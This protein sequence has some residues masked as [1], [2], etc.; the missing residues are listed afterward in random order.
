LGAWPGLGAEMTTVNLPDGRRITFPDG[1][2]EAD[3]SSAIGQIMGGQAAPEAVPE[4][5]IGRQLGLGARSAVSGLTAIPGMVYDAASAPFNILRMGYNAA[6]GSEGG[7]IPSASSRAS[8]AMDALGAPK[9]SAPAERTAGAVIEGMAGA[10]T[11]IGAGRAIA[12]KSTS[13]MAKKIGELLAAG[14]VI[15]TAAGGAGGFA[16]E[17][18][19]QG[20]FGPLGQ[21]VAGLAGNVA[22]AGGLTAAGVGINATL[23]RLAQGKAHL[24]AGERTI[25]NIIQGIGE[26]DLSAGIDRVQRRLKASPDT[27]LVDV[28]GESGV[29]KARASTNIEGPGANRGAAFIEER[30]GG[31]GTRMQQAADTLAPE[32]F[33]DE[34]ERL[35]TGQMAK[36]KPLYEEAHSKPIA[37]DDHLMRLSREPAILS[38]L[39][40]GLDA[41][42][43]LSV[44]K[45]TQFDPGQYAVTGFNPAGDPIIGK[46]PNL[47]MFDAAKR[48]LDTMIAN[49][50]DPVTQKLSTRGGQL[51]GLRRD[52]V[53]K[54]DEMTTDQSGRSAYK[55]ARAAWAG[56][57]SV[58]DA[59]WAGRKFAQGDREIKAA[60]FAKMNEGER[61]AFKMGIRREITGMIDSNTQLAPGKFASKHVGLWKRLE[62]IF[63]EKELSAFRRETDSEV[64]KLATELAVG[65]RAGSQTAGL[66]QDIKDLNTVPSELQDAAIQA[67]SGNPV[68]GIIS[69]LGSYARKKTGPS[70][71]TASDLAAALFEL[72]PAKQA[73]ILKKLNQTPR[74]ARQN[75]DVRALIA[76]LQTNI[77]TQNYEGLDQ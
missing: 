5:T 44:R 52:F 50:R 6:M 75:P 30:Q 1:M 73:E 21:G 51:E 36:A 4:N 59:M 24:N 77:A 18:A 49:E 27:A 23:R 69:A 12:E 15:Q 47:R 3:I 72:D 55:E 76:A 7:F 2:G 66:T 40:E 71:S 57:A 16:E 74:L 9:P 33:Y 58:K 63:D 13:A 68:Q 29:K 48:G 32:G 37:I 39:K 53:A 43:M 25:S 61:D 65:P 56:P 41:D 67:L 19:Q 46:T 64:R 35:N 42:R 17:A 38:G 34:L 11:P 60:A 14:P 45:N 31:R 20:G 26:G 10:M 54:L 22:T 62:D 28:L 8:E 70:V